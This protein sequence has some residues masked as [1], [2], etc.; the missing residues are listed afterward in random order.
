MTYFTDNVCEKMMVQKPIYR[1]EER[2][3][4][5]K[6]TI[7]QKQKKIYKNLIIKKVESSQ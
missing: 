1:K 4:V 6:N 7:P 5:H 2:A 3:P